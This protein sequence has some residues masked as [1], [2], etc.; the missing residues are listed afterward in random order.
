MLKEISTAKAGASPRAIDVLFARFAAQYGRQWLDLWVDV[1]MGAVKSEWS[2]GLSGI[3]PAQT[4]RAMEHLGK[5]P[6]T[7]PEFKALC[8]HF[9]AN[10]GQVL[11]S[12]VDA[13]REPMP[14]KVRDQLRAFVGRSTAWAKP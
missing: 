13:R 14:D 5:F 11:L 9:R 6:P 3:R 8:R 2:S 10:D 12:I 7:L 4:E 1:D